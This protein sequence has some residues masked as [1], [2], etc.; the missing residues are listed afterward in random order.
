MTSLKDTKAP[1]TFAQDGEKNFTHKGTL[2]FG[3]NRTL[4]RRRAAG[5]PQ[6]LLGFGGSGHL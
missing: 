2:A 6:F 3:D 1:F 4:P 5:K